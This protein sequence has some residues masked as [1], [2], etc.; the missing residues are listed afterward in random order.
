MRV[1]CFDMDFSCRTYSGYVPVPDNMP[2][3]RVLGKHQARLRE[4]KEAFQ[5]A[6]VESDRPGKREVSCNV[7]KEPCY[8][9]NTSLSASAPL[10]NVHF[11]KCM[12]ISN[13]GEGCC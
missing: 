9:S 11:N 10:S 4:V 5:C 2:I 13:L 8:R 3:L 1:Y 7:R 6:I 12:S